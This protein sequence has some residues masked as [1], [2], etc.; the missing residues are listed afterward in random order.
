MT[1]FRIYADLSADFRDKPK[2]NK[3][4]LWKFDRNRSVFVL[5]WTKIWHRLISPIIPAIEKTKNFDYLSVIKN[6]AI[7]VD[8]ASMHYEIKSRN[9]QLAT[10]ESA[11]PEIESI[12]LHRL[13]IKPNVPHIGSVR[14]SID[15]PSADLC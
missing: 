12:Q 15:K 9:L 13:P 4:D 3:C 14:Q 8:E 7:V 10:I 2:H 6:I 1:T 5:D 11:I